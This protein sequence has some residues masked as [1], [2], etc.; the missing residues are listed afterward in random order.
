MA[1]SNVAQLL[2]EEFFHKVRSV[3]ISAESRVQHMKDRVGNSEPLLRELDHMRLDLRLVNT[4]VDRAR[5]QNRLLTEEESLIRFTSVSTQELI[6]GIEASIKEMQ[7]LAAHP[8]AVR[9][10][11]DRHSLGAI[12]NMWTDMRLLV[13][14]IGNILDNA[15]KYSFDG[16]VVRIR[17][18]RH[19]RHAEIV[20][21]N[22][23]IR[24]DTEDVEL[25][26]QERWRSTLAQRHTDKGLGIGLWLTD[27]ILRSLNAELLIWPTDMS[28]MTRFG[29]RLPESREG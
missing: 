19:E 24:L 14:A 17:A 25:C 29:I 7:F 6:K 13:V 2:A 15:R 27:R 26:R 12:G 23:G 20:V 5:I 3:L 8:N 10:E 11:L 22:T 1:D 28:G 9:Y 4:M 16:T 18:S 21:E